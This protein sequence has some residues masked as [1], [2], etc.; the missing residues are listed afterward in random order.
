MMWPNSGG[1]DP[2]EDDDDDEDEEYEDEYDE[3]EDT[4]AEGTYT[5]TMGLVNDGTYNDDTGTYGAD[6]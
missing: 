1:R 3:D 5:G 6:H 2:F 4:Y